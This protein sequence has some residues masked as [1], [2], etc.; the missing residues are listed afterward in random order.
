MRSVL[1]CFV[2]LIILDGNFVS[3]QTT[4]RPV[5]DLDKFRLEFKTESS[6]INTITSDF[7]QEKQLIAL[8]ETIHSQGKF[9]FRREDKVRINYEN[10]FLYQMVI[11]GD[12]ISIRD[13]EKVNQMNT[14]SSKLFQ[15]VNRI[16]LDCVRGSVLDSRDFTATVFENAEQYKIVL[17]P[18]G[19]AL[20]DFFTTINL[21]IDKKTYSVASIEMN[22]TGGDKTVMTF[23]NKILNTPVDDAVFSM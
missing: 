9:W 4:F 7:Q 21:F 15:Q 13:N 17:S 14:R 1:T 23:T 5:S 20:R 10:P 6:K 18:Q 19:K 8:T 12:R 16:M 22:E 2:L 11:N 3:A